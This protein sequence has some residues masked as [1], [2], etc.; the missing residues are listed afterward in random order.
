[1]NDLAGVARLDAEQRISRL[2]EVREVGRRL[3]E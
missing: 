3:V 2:G 1:M